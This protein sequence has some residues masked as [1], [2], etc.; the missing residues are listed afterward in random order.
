M[1]AKLLLI[2]LILPVIG[3]GQ[4][5]YK[6]RGFAS[7]GLTFAPTICYRTLSYSSSNQWI[8]DQRDAKEVANFGFNAGITTHFF[9]NDK[10]KIETGLLYSR[11]STKT[12]F[13]ELQWTDPD[14]SLPIKSKTIYHFHYFGL[15]VIVNYKFFE[16]KKLNLYAAMGLVP[17]L[18]FEKRTKVVVEYSTGDD[19]S[20]TSPERIG[21]SKINLD[22]VIGAGMEYLLSERFYLKAG[23][24]FRH[25]VNSIIVDKDAKEF[26]FSAGINVSISYKLKERERD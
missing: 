12:K 14:P 1:R 7:I 4:V 13:E 20:Y 10:L 6:T 26:L 21:Y 24:F 23:P 2:L 3:F 11:K 25:S 8:A 17:D 19:D 18:F 9:I 15:P 22:I 5:E 16:K